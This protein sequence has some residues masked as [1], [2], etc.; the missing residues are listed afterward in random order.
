MGEPLRGSLSAIN[1]IDQTCLE[2]PCSSNITKTELKLAADLP[3][4]FCDV[5][6]VNRL[7][8]IFNKVD[9]AMLDT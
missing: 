2:V 3:S 5:I 4:V 9:N 7:L 6:D 8:E 1:Y